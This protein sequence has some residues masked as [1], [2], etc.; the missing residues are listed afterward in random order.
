MLPQLG[1]WRLV[2]PPTEVISAAYSILRNEDNTKIS[3]GTHIGKS[4]V[5]L[6]VGLAK[7][8]S[9]PTSKAPDTTWNEATGSWPLLGASGTVSTTKA[10][11]SVATV[12]CRCV[13]VG[14]FESC[15]SYSHTRSRKQYA[16][17]TRS[18][19]MLNLTRADAPYVLARSFTV[20]VGT[21]CSVLG[22]GSSSFHFLRFVWRQHVRPQI[23]RVR[24]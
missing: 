2:P 4:G 16:T 22:A 24:P 9:C 23:K 7:T 10:G 11:G 18:A 12:G 8:L 6:P 3:P 13:G 5:G 15:A 1:S 14:L 19:L 20:E 21:A 17:T